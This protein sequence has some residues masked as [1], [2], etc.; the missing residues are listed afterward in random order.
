MA[1]PSVGLLAEVKWANHKWMN[2]KKKEYGHGLNRIE[3]GLRGGN[4]TKCTFVET[5]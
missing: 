5:Q 2:D 4:S 3:T 1:E